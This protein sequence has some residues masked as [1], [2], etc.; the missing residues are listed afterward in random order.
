VCVG[1][2]EIIRRRQFLA[3][4]PSWTE[5]MLRSPCL[6]VARNRSFEIP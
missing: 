6:S 1:D 5:W 2:G 4:M 3:P